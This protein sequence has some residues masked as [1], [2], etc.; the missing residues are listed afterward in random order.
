MSVPCRFCG[1]EY[2]NTQ[3]VKAHLKGCAVY[4]ARPGNSPANAGSLREDG[5][6]AES[7]AEMFRVTAQLMVAVRRD[8]GNPRDFLP[9][10]ER[11]YLRLLIKKADWGQIEWVMRQSVPDRLAA[12]RYPPVPLP[13]ST[14]LG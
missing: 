1:K 13:T 7:Q 14:K 11:E 8:M 12:S 10:S 3:A 9:V 6:G 2:A 5:G 4:R